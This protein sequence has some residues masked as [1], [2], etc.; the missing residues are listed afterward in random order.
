MAAPRERAGM[1]A[2]GKPDAHRTIQAIWRIEAA[3]LIAG[4]ARLVR[5]VGTA[6]ELAQDALVAALEAWPESGIPEKPG[7]SPRLTARRRSRTSPR[8][9]TT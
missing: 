7:A 2:E 3:R 9:S 5:D 1:P 8:R 6:E 4:V